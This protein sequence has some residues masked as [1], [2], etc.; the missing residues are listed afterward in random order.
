LV[1]V[2]TLSVNSHRIYSIF[3]SEAIMQ[4]LNPGVFFKHTFTALKYPNY[5]LWFW[6]QMVSLFGTWMQMTAQGYLVFELTHSAVYLG[7]LGFASGVP[8]WVFTLYGGIIADRMS[9]RTLL[10]IT[11]TTMMILSLILTFLVFGKWVQPWHIILIAFALGAANAFDAP[12]RQAIVVDLVDHEDLTNA[13][14][15]N[16][17][18]FNSASAVGPAAAGVIY[19]LWGPGWCFL[20]NALSFIAVIVSLLMMKLKPI[21]RLSEK[22]STWS[23]L[24]EGVRY[25]ALHP[26]IRILIG[27]VAITSL[28][29]FS[30]LTLIPAWAVRVLKGDATTNG[31]LRAALGLGALAGA[32]FIAS[33]GRFRFKGKLLTLGTFISPILML[34]F[35]LFHSL[36]VSLLVLVASGAAGILIMNLTNA[37]VQTLALDS[38]RGRVMSIYS[39]TFFGLMPIGS[40]IVGLLAEGLGE[41]LAFFIFSAAALVFAAVIWVWVPALRRQP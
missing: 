26:V 34:V 22:T 10:V 37:L 7:Y 12:A 14:A 23:D 33:L 3:V 1:L 9:R 41:P 31:L 25:V 21:F 38:L 40:L 28:L 18:M 20:I 6:G 16:S 4:K 13:V 32:I 27:I 8:A 36:H 17:T 19:G 35:S 29:R 39:L 15:L 5:R 11:Q 2:L 24:K 30:A